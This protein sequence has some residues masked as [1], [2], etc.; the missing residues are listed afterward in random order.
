MGREKQ[1]I[2]RDIKGKSLCLLLFILLIIGTSACA[3]TESAG[4]TAST[5]QGSEMAASVT[6]DAAT[7]PIIESTEPSVVLHSGLREDGSFDEGTWFIGDSMTCILITD[8]LQPNEFIGE[9]A[10]TGK[11]GAHI[12]AFF[13][14][15]VMSATSY[16]KCVFRPEHEGLGYDDVAKLLGEQATAIYMMWGTNY[17]W[18]AYAD[19]YIEI[20]DFLLETCPNATVHLQL[21]PWGYEE[22]VEFETVNE[23]IREAYAHY[24][25]MGE[26]RVLLID[27]FTAIGKNHDSGFIHLNYAGNENWYNAIV[28]HAK[29]N[30][31]S[32]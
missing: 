27:T 12:T 11:F 28:E 26:E 3:R 2:I 29:S 7:E 13:D 31:L 19:A 8:Y 18:N 22:L 14:D 15:T 24:Q 16:N 6:T 25:E 4:D 23:W 5:E 32:Q 1:R 30:D 20:V 21:I 17:T 9:A 10:Y